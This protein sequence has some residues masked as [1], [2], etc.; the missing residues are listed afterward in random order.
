MALHFSQ[1]RGRRRCPLALVLSDQLRRHPARELRDTWGRFRCL[2]TSFDGQQK[3]LYRASLHG[4]RRM[5]DRGFAEIK[6]MGKVNIYV[7]WTTRRVL[8][9]HKDD[10]K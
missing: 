8:T 7:R 1:Y 3:R 9:M 10:V 4:V 6:T 5:P 2:T